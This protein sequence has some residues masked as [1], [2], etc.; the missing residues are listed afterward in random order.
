MRMH[1][2]LFIRHGV[3]TKDD[4]QSSIVSAQVLQSKCCQVWLEFTLPF[5]QP[6]TGPLLSLQLLSLEL[7]RQ[8]LP[9]DSRLVGEHRRVKSLSRLPTSYSGQEKIAGTN[10]ENIK[11]Q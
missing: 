5:S 7:I 10:P 1:L 3:A 9:Y 11:R 2:V 8:G 6:V 4:D